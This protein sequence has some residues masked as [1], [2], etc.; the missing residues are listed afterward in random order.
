[1]HTLDQ[2]VLVLDIHPGRVGY[3]SF[4]GQQNLLDWGVKC[5]RGGV[6]AVRVPFAT[7]I[8]QLLSEWQP[9]TVVLSKSGDSQILARTKAVQ[10]QA[11]A[12][13]AAVRVVSA[14]DMNETFS[15]TRNKHERARILAA[16]FPELADR[17]PAKRKAWQSEHYQMSIFDAVA[18][19]MAY[20]ARLSRLQANPT[21]ME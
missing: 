10:A 20:F 18:L 7:K 9:D 17:L 6:N 21:T 12:S 14:E 8:S 19:G 11:K 16:S 13:G 4:E 5:F 1:M 3:A 2:R 15:S